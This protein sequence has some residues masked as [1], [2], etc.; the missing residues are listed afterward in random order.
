VLCA[1]A[2][3]AIA[4]VTLIDTFRLEAPDSFRTLAII[5]ELVVVGLLAAAAV[6]HLLSVARE[7]SRHAVIESLAE[8][9]SVPRSIEEIART[10]VAQLVGSDVASSA[11]LAVAKEDGQWLEPVAAS[12]YPPHS[13]IQPRDA[14]GLVAAEAIVQKGAQLTDPWLAPL[15]ARSGQRPWV[16]HVPILSD[17][18]VL[19]LLLLVSPPRSLLADK[20]LLRTVSALIAAALDH[21][22]LYEAAYAPPASAEEIALERH[23]LLSAVASELAPA[24][25][26]VESHASVIAGEDTSPDTIEDARRLSALSQSIEQLKAM[27]QDLATL[28]RPETDSETHEPAPEASTDVARVARGVIAAFAPAFAAR[29]QAV[30]LELPDGPL[31]AV[32]SVDAV[33]RLLLHLLS[34]A[35]RSAPD[36]GRVIVR[37]HDNGDAIRI[38]VE[39]SGPALDVLE[40]THIFEPFYRVAPGLPEVPGAGL[41]LS[42]AQQLA[43]S[44]GGAVW[45]EPRPGGGT[46]YYV[47]LPASA[48]PRTEG[49]EPPALAA[50]STGIIDPA[51]YPAIDGPDDEQAAGTEAGADVEAFPYETEARYGDEV[52]FEDDEPTQPIE[53]PDVREPV[54]GQEPP[55]SEGGRTEEPATFAQ[56]PRSEFDADMAD[57]ALESNGLGGAMLENDDLEAPETLDAAAMN[58]EA[59][60]EHGTAEGVAVRDDPDGGGDPREDGAP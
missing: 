30:E 23:M 33:E 55:A 20:R 34:N 7:R 43:E 44:Q 40:R 2:A 37:A 9:F 57:D 48:R 25:V 46:A 50:V 17:D 19:G 8:A 13:G 38:E 59:E 12:G 53:L 5:V 3:L 35:N 15:A 41:G 54:G 39:D 27:L 47:E 42:V 60:E 10:S 36:E 26:A 21:A 49:G 29:M 4:H 16:A 14:A 32:A 1:L 28:G 24:I 51:G 18:E 58:G 11:L 31:P 45:A 52:E 6:T 56:P 22:Q